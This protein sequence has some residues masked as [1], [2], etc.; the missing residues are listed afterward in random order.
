MT[1]IEADGVRSNHLRLDSPGMLM[2]ILWYKT[3]VQESLIDVLSVAVAQRYSVL[4]T[5]RNDTSHNW[6]IHANMM[7]SMF[8]YVPPNLN[9]S[10]LS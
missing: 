3:D 1:I 2:H 9:P 6:A 4:V 8:D 7:T 5:A 10:L